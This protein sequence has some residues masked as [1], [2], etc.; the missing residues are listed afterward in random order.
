MKKSTIWF[1]AIS[2]G[3]SF[4]ALLVMQRRYG[5]EV[6]EIRQQQFEEAVG[7]ALY[8]AV[9]TMELRD[10]RQSIKADIMDKS[11]QQ[12]SDD[13][14]LYH[15]IA[16]PLEQDLLATATDTGRNRLQE[17]VLSGYEGKGDYLIEA[18]SAILKKPQESP[19]EQ[20]IDFN[21]LDRNIRD[22]LRNC[23]IKLPYHFTV[24]TAAGRRV[25]C[26]PDYEDPGDCPTYE[27]EIFKNGE[28]GQMGI[29][30][31][32]F[33]DMSKYIFSSVKFLIPALVFTIILF[34]IFVFTIYTIFRQ[35][36]LSEIKN[37]FINNMTHE[38]KTPISSISLASQMLSDTSIKKSDQMINH[39]TGVIAD[40]TKRLRFQ[41]DKVLQMSM[42]DRDKA[43]TFKEKEIDAN[44]VISDVINTFRLKVEQSGGSIDW[45]LDAQDATLF[46][47]EMHFTN[48]IFNLLDNAY[49][50]KSTERPLHISIRTAD[51]SHHRLRIE[52]Q[53]NGIGI[54]SEDLKKIFERF[55][56][57]S[58]GNRHD[59]KGFGLGLAYVH[60]VIKYH[61]GNIHAESTLGQ[62]TTF[63]IQLPLL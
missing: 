5:A 53:D 50:Y 60:N 13:S 10:I 56:R 24:S 16:S 49:K 63:I 1:I 47:D 28:R 46:A 62:G 18:L 12:T 3:L 29:I 34:A 20:R 37:D 54:R 51:D 31:V 7:H 39:L 40:E 58:T 61:H 19:L 59:V 33:P 36:R 52:I 17:E 41:V 27:Q 35:K 9:H 6:V 32:Y 48:V 45:Q 43:P 4:I 21:A 15:L 25:Y 30:T 11:G 22:E 38:F 23:G 2:M 57:V 26:C 8:Q 55:Y 42:F 44:Q 14:I